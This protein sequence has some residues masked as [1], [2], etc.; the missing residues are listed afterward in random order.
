MTRTN[1][2]TVDTQCKQNPHYTR[3]VCIHMHVEVELYTIMVLDF[4]QYS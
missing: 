4:N 3:Y 1:L 2:L